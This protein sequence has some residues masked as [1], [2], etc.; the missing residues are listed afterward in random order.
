MRMHRLFTTILAVSL[1]AVWL[2]PAASAQD[3]AAV[4]QR[5]RTELA[6]ILKKDPAQLPL[7]KPVTGLGATELDVIEWQ[8]AAERT[9]RVDISDDKL[10]DE[11]AKPLAVRKDLTISSMAT[12]VA[13]S[14]PWPAGKTK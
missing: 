13:T 7:D 8:M 1:V 14:K 3:R 2:A 11:K 10:F 9:F 6:K 12:V 4:E 5:L